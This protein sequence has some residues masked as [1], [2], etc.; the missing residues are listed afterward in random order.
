M[1]KERGGRREDEI[2]EKEMERRTRDEGSMII[3]TEK[4]ATCNKEK[5][6]NNPNKVI[7]VKNKFNAVWSWYRVVTPVPL[8]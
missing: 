3:Q 7:L 4:Q 6:H 5:E 2:G 1:R 8:Q